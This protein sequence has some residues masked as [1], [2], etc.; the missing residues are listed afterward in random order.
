MTSHAIAHGINETSQ[1]GFGNHQTE[2]GIIIPRVPRGNRNTGYLA[3]PIETFPELQKVN[4]D[5]ST[6]K[7]PEPLKGI[8]KFLSTLFTMGTFEQ[9]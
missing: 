8:R 1:W 7:S 2:R 3:V 5:F 6:S 9:V 4:F